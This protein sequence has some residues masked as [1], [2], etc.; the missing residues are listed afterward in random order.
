MTRESCITYPPKS[1]SVVV[2]QSLVAICEGA[3][4]ANCA[5]AILNQFIYWTD[6]KIEHAKQV[7][8]HND[9]AIADGE[10]PTQ[11]DS[12]WIYKKSEEM[13]EEL[14]HL[15]GRNKIVDNTVW[16][17]STGYLHSRRNPIYRWDKTL[18]YH[19]DIDAVQSRIHAL[20]EFK[21]KPSIVENQTLDSS[22]IIIREP[23]INQAIPEIT[24]ETTTKKKEVPASQRAVKKTTTPKAILNPMMEAIVDALQWDRSI[25]TGS[26]WSVIRTAAKQL[27]EI[28]VALD[29]VVHLKRECDARNYRGYTAMAFP[30]VAPD[31]LPRIRAISAVG[32]VTSNGAHAHQPAQLQPF[33]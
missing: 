9:A 12:L 11:D 24:T 33:E 5:A 27:I 20:R 32:A 29:E 17:V 19:L 28:N 14:L 18:Q 6:Y 15:F 30:K 26:N 16:L 22:K 25:I 31:V 2:R 1:I 8:Y 3:P 13:Q 10:L 7:K 23:E 4:D 21:I